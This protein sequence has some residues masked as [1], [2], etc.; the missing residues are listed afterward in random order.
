SLLTAVSLA[1][2]SDPATSVPTP[3]ESSS[4]GGRTGGPIEYA[5]DPVPSPVVPGDYIITFAPSVTD[6]RGLANALVSQHGGRL[7]HVYASALNGF[8][9]NFNPTAI[10]ALAKNPQI[11]R[12]EADAVVSGSDVQAS[13]T[14][15][16]DRIDQR[17]LP[18]DRSYVYAN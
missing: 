10:A 16:L 18:L 3:I 8:A 14:W 7:K 11:A 9:A 1:A 13:P 6:S 15:G 12:I 17:G 4:S 5:P 2:C